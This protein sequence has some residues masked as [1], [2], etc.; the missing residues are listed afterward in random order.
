M[1][2]K[3][4]KIMPF[5][6]YEKEIQKYAH[7]PIEELNCPLCGD[8]LY[9]NLDMSWGKC[10]WHYHCENRKCFFTVDCSAVAAIHLALPY[11]SKEHPCIELHNN[12]LTIF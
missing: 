8:K 6:E 4:I 12:E 5:K 7:D 1:E 2:F 9:L 3:T 10:P 11:V